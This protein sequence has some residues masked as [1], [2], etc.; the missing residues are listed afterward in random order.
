MPGIPKL[1]LVEGGFEELSLEL[2]E[3]LDKLRGEGSNVL[4]EVTP[5]TAEPVTEEQPEPTRKTDTDAVL[6]KLVT[7]S[8]ALNT[9][10]EREL[11]AAYNLLIHLVGQAEE[12]SRY[13]PPVCRN[14]TS[15]ITSSPQNGTGIALGILGTLFNTLDADDDVR[16][17]V[18]LSIVELLKRTGNYEHIRPQ[19]QNLD[20]WLA[21]WE[22]EPAEERQL[23]R[24]LSECASTSG[25]PE[26]SYMYLLKAVR[27]LQSEPTSQQARDLSLNALK[28]ALQS[29]KHFDFQ[30]LT[31]LSSIQALRESDETWSDLLELFVDQT[32]EDLQDFKDGNN[33][34]FADQGLNEDVLD[35]KMRLLTLATLAAQA[36]ETRTIPYSHIAK[37]LS[38]PGEDVEM[39]VIDS[40]RSGLVEGKL[41]QQREEFLVHR[42]T[43]RTFG[44]K[45]WREIASRLETWKASLRNVLEV[46]R[47]QKEEFVREK[48]AEAE[49][50]TRQNAWGGGRN[51]GN[52]GQRGGEM[53]V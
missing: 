12:P 16:F 9:A 50:P 23:F 43:H 17:H 6:K 14:L 42:A 37:A 31:T 13:L 36:S 25:E 8:S 19:L 27:T 32:Y 39:W 40:I 53:V 41:S 20:A 3:Y 28:T 22:M 21:E 1:S 38:I 44:D 4:S 24:I 34:F 2:A 10:P 46:V 33:T 47:Q 45:Q 26:E 35:K 11:Q 15:P 51:Y 52:R 5:L 49:G 7:A 18:L 48:E 29:E 30:D